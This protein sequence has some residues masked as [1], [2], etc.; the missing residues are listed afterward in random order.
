MQEGCRS[1]KKS[2]RVMA[3]V[4]VFKEK[5]MR[6]I[7]AFGPQSGKSDCEKDQFYNEMLCEWD[8]QT[9]GKMALC[10]S[11][12]N[13]FCSCDHHMMILC[14]Q[15]FSQIFSTELQNYFTKKWICDYFLFDFHKIFKKSCLIPHALKDLKSVS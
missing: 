10:L 14:L 2:D 11:D 7:S 5:A 6:T 8:L 13:S 4:L 9:A 15:C 3:M 1:L 12:F